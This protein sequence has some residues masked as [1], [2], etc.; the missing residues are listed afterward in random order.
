MKQLKQYIEGTLGLIIEPVPFPSAKMG[1]LP[2]FIG[3]TYT[4]EHAV[5]FDRELVFA[6]P[7]ANV[8]FSIQ[9]IEKHFELIRKELNVDVILVLS[10]LAAYYRK[11]LIEKGISFVVP[12]KQ[13]FLPNL[14]IDLRENYTHPKTRERGL[15][16][17]P[18]AQFLLIYH[19]LHRHEKKQIE[20]YSFKKI[21]K[22]LGYTAMA[23]T[24]VAENLKQ[25][26]IIE[27]AGD[28]EKFIRFKLDRAELWRDLEQRNLWIN[29]VLKKV[30]VDEKPNGVFM[31]L[32]NATA[33]P[34]YT[35]MNPSR[36]EFFA[37]DKTL[38]YGLQKNNVLRNANES[39]GKYCLEIWKYNP[40]TLVGEMPNDSAVV[41]PLSLYLSLKENHDERMEM[42]LEQIINKFIW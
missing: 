8:G 31:L 7:R 37:L 5:M 24:K 26:E 15:K 33:L 35:D 29:P 42:A 27:V 22:V 12:G 39:E 19:L 16:L 10:E 21:A 14:L 34:Q 4:L 36:Q 41:D 25:L 30:F 13:L 6:E 40:L 23:I 20:S 3:E 28:K 38:Y 1:G 2:M 17:L 18:S 32:S 11:R 9:Q